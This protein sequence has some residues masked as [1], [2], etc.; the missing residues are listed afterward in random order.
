MTECPTNMSEDHTESGT[1]LSHEDLRLCGELVLGTA[2]L[3]CSEMASAGE[4]N[5]A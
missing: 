2:A 5:L 1:A 4:G 3:L